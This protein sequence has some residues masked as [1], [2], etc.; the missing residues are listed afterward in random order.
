M[1][2]VG[3]LLK[4]IFVVGISVSESVSV[5]TWVVLIHEIFDAHQLMPYA[6]GG[7]GSP[8]QILWRS[9]AEAVQVLGHVVDPLFT[10]TAFPVTRPTVS[11]YREHIR[12]VHLYGFGVGAGGPQFHLDARAVV[13]VFNYSLPD[14][15]NSAVI[16]VPIYTLHR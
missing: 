12:L 5:T 4:T 13:P 15:T 9:V 14:P 10:V 1:K 3:R 2:H 7:V 11:G 6:L 16:A 8:F